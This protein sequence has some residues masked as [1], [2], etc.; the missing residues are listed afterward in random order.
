[1]TNDEREDVLRRGL[2]DRG[3][4]LRKYDAGYAITRGSAVVVKAGSTL[5]EQNFWTLDELELRVRLW[6]LAGGP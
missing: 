2:A 1:M 5:E 4:R 6:N 3:E